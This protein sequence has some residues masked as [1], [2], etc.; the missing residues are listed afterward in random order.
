[1]N[2]EVLTLFPEIIDNYSNTSIIKRAKENGIVNIQAVNFRDFS[3]SKHH[4]V[5]DAPFGGGAGM[6]LSPQ[7]IASA[8][9]KLNYNQK[10]VVY[11]TPKGKTFNQKMA[12]ELSVGK[13]LILICGHYEGLDQR[14][15]DNYVD[16]EISIGDYVL[17]GGE[18]GALVIIDA[19]TRLLPGALAE[20]SLDEESF[21]NCLLE[22]PQYTRPRV[23]K[24]YE[25]PEILLSGNH[26]KIEEYRLME[27]IRLTLQNRPDL[28]QKGIRNKVFDERIL[29]LIKEIK[30]RLL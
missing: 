1:M 26:Q 27:S 17:S 3:D 20:S 4:S 14:I 13:D 25:V 2:I 11:L 16:L 30:N 10:K 19:V 23:F 8:L 6:V 28:I 18:I 9:K 5:D 24:D 7:P 15:I 29:K 12:N 22:Y 21:S